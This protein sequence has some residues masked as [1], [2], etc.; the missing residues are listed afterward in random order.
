MFRA[1]FCPLCFPSRNGSSAIP[2]VPRCRAAPEARAH[3][4]PE[5]LRWVGAA[6][7]VRL[8]VVPGLAESGFRLVLTYHPWDIDWIYH[9]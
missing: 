4:L 7:G 8:R 2:C 5:A 1:P 3:A 6:G 9:L